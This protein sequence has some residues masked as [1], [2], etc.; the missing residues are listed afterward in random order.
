MCANAR[1]RAW[2]V[3]D[4]AVGADAEASV[5]RRFATNREGIGRLV[6][7]LDALLNAHPEVDAAAPLGGEIW[8][9]DPLNRPRSTLFCRP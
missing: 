5:A 2:T 6:V 4:E 8:L 1:I 7:A 3:V 9:E